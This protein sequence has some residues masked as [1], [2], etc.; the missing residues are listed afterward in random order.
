MPAV[1]ADHGAV[2]VRHRP[3]AVR[4]LHDAAV[5]ARGEI[6]ALGPVVDV[7]ARL[8]RPP[9]HLGLRE[10][11][12][13]EQHAR[14][15][16]LAEQAEEVRLVLGRVRGLAHGPPAGVRVAPEARVMPGRERVDT[17]RGVRELLD[18][19]PELHQPVATHARVRRPARE[20]LRARVLEDKLPVRIPKVDDVVGDAEPGAHARG[21][22]DVRRL[23][24]TVAGIAGGPRRCGAARRSR[25]RR[26]HPARWTW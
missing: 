2:G 24:G 6:L 13:R 10:V 16:V 25:P 21:V 26:P 8:L 20:V 14:E 15:L 19:Q 22:L 12:E 17:A 9:S 1:A 7:Q 23:P 4:K 3:L 5:A 11:A 18:E